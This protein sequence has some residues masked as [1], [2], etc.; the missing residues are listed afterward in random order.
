MCVPPSSTSFEGEAAVN[1]AGRTVCKTSVALPAVPT[2]NANSPGIT[3]P[4]VNVIAA[5]PSSTPSTVA[6]EM[7]AAALTAVRCCRRSPGFGLPARIFSMRN[8]LPV[9]VDSASA[10]RRIWPPPSPNEPRVVDVA[11]DSRSVAVEVVLASYC[12]NPLPI[13]F[14]TSSLLTPA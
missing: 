7:L 1:N 5:A 12:A 3:P 4:G 11:P 8:G 6:Q 2:A 9:T 10:V 13:L 14:I